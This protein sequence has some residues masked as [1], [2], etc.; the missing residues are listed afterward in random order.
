VTRIAFIDKQRSWTG[1][2]KRTFL[3]A[4]ALDR[5]KF[6]PIFIGQPGSIL[7]QRMSEL[8]IPV[9]EVD[10]GGLQFFPAILKV[11]RILRRERVAL[12]DAHGYR[13]HV[14]SVIAARFAGTKGVLRTKHN[15]VP[16]KG[17]VFSRFIYNT[18]TAKVV[19]ISDH[20]RRVLIESGMPPEK[21]ITIHSSVDLEQFSPRAKAPAILEAFGL[22]ENTEVVGMVARIHRRKGFDYLLQAIP[23][24]IDKG[25]DR[26]FLIV[27]KGHERFQGEIAELGIEAHVIS[28]GHRRD[29][30]DILSVIDIFVLP[31]LEE[32]LGIAILEAMAMGKPIVSTRVGGIPEAV[33]DGI[34][35]ILVP[36]ADTRAIAAALRE[37]LN[38]KE[39]AG[40]MGRESRRIAEE[41]FSR[42]RMI[43][44][45]LSLFRRVLDSGP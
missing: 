26:K 34:N 32:G 15:H 2:T 10:M 38:D 35:G 14:I 27:G 1:Q 16:L 39:K 20:I 3:I 4:S 33:E 45:T 25:V 24:L 8:G 29:V 43:S 12:V 21:V 22:R 40:R 11:S 19:A 41:R 28:P 42:R 36:P 17:G 23:M 9:F 6:E 13:D 44:D 18:L 5:E 7:G 31:S 37:L 30:A